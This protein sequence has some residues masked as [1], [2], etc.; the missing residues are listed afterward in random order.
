MRK[1]VVT[2]FAV[3]AILAFLVPAANATWYKCIVAQIVP[4]EGGNV[5]VQFLPGTD[6]DRF[7][8]RS[9]GTISSDAPGGNKM[10][11]TLLTAIS[12][13]YEVT[14]LMDNT[15]SWTSQPIKGV[16]LVVQ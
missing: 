12:L 1:T 15:P 7:T 11:A 14:I 9:R 5:Y 8:E 6:E 4:R 2:L 10:L 3:L 13:G 16:G